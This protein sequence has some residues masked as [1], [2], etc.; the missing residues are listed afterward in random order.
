MTSALDAEGTGSAAAAAAA[1]SGRGATPSSSP[2]DSVP[3]GAVEKGRRRLEEVPLAPTT[4]AARNPN[5][6]RC[7]RGRRGGLAIRPS[8]P[9]LLALISILSDSSPVIFLLPPSPPRP[10]PSPPQA[11]EGKDARPASPP[12]QEGA[13]STVSTLSADALAGE[14]PMQCAEEWATTESSRLLAPR[15]AEFHACILACSSSAV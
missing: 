8:S 10:T 11:G 14:W 3:L 4:G 2:L 15:P 6:L 7:E 12:P 5:P 9:R 13:P 1:K